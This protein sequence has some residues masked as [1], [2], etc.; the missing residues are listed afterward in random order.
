MLV[1]EVEVKEAVDVAEGGMVADSVSLIGI[2]Q[3]AENV[4]GRGDGQ[5]EQRAGD[6]LQLAPAPPLAGQQQVGNGRAD[7]KDRRDQALG[8]QRQRQAAHIQ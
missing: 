4:P 5:K 1:D 8:Q 6:R 3:A 7:K 2:G